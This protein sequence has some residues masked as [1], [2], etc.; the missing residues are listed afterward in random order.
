MAK[1][2]DNHFREV[3][4]KCIDGEQSA[5][6]PGRL[7]SDNVL[8]AYEILHTL[9][10]KKLGK[11]GWMA[12]K[13]DM[14]KAYDRVEWSFVQEIM[15][16]MGF[17]PNWINSIMNCIAT[18]SYSVVL[19]GQAG[20]IFHP[21]RGLRQGV[22]LSPFLFLIC[23]EGLSSLMKKSIQEGHLKGV[24]ASRRGPQISHLLFADDYILFGEA[25]ERGAGFIKR[26]LCEYGKCSGQQVN[27]EK[28]T[29]LFSSNTREEEKRVVTQILG[30]RFSNDPEHYLGLPNMVGRR[31]KEAF[32]NLKDRFKQKIDNW[33]IRHLSQ[34]GKE[35]F[36]KALYRYMQWLV[37]CFVKLYASNWRVSLQNFGGKR[38]IVDGESIGV[39]GKIYALQKK[40]VVWFNIALLA[41]QGWHLIHYP[42][43]LL[44][45]I[46][47][48]HSWRNSPSLT[49]KNVW[50]A[51]RLL[52][53]GLGWRIEKSDRVSVSNDHW[54]PGIAN[55]RSNDNTSSTK[56]EF[57]S[58]LIEPTTR[59]WKVEL[60][61]HIFPENIAQKILQLPLAEEA[62]EDFQ[63]WCGEN[64]GE[65]TVR[66]A[67]KLLQE[68]N[69]D[70]NAYLLQIEGKNFYKKL[71]SL[72]LPTK[73]L[74]T[75]WRLS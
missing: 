42:N 47:Y 51:K 64:S 38:V 58:S 72:Q 12:V 37:F 52:Q 50:T 61:E 41:K 66:S 59:K 8:L 19:N 40:M 35:V 68:V 46:S 3:L 24:K 71:W 26:V 67:Y 30:V 53:D 18:V 70:P 22:P 48:M 25:N 36:I 11:K 6:V 16:K 75:V 33:S 60:I 27:F 39:C 56:I 28:S 1:T 10:R 15:R 45:Q 55:I 44:A 65:F 73:I 9:K 43:S 2:I 20:D 69:L 29:V 21:S 14:S 4:E 7:I 17:D 63:V 31:K 13:L 23:G 74:I 62:H 57:V 54:I 32:Q 34:G 49:W 5:F